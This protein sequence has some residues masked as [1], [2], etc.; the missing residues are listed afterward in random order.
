MGRKTKYK[1]KFAK[2]LRNGI[3]RT[4]DIYC[5]REYLC[6]IER[7]CWKW[8]IT[9]KTYYNWV[10]EFT[11]FRE[12]H[13]RGERDFIVCCQEA[14]ED[15]MKLGKQANA[16]LTKFYMQNIGSGM[17]DKKEITQT[18]QENKI[19]RIEIE[20]IKPQTVQIEDNSN[21]GNVIDITPVIDEHSK[22]KST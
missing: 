17:S 14:V 9:P 1:P 10:E 5:G 7:L 15:G 20:Y 2:E 22:V 21:R 3:R 19:H 11:S 13:E 12:A 16:V 18:V 6:T 8:D 4:P